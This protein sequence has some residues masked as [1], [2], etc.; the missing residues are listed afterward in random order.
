VCPFVVFLLFA[1]AFKGVGKGLVAAVA[2]P[3]SGV[4]DA[5]SATAEG[6]DAALSRRRVAMVATQRRRLA[7]A[8]GGDG[9]LLPMVRDGSERQ[10][11]VEQ[12]GQALMR[13]TLASVP[14]SFMRRRQGLAAGGCLCVW[15]SVS[16]TCCSQNPAV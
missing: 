16:E 10:A 6:F 8:V 1:G 15:V 12:L 3:V 2:N 7:R 9:R 4:L 5:L 13:N 11:C 14:D